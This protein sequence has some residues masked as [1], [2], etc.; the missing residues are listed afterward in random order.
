M[1]NLRF[2]LVFICLSTLSSCSDEECPPC[3]TPPEMFVFNIVDE[4]SGENVFVSGAYD[5]NDLKVT[6][7][8]NNKAIEYDYISENNLGYI[9]IH[10]IGWQTEIVNYHFTIGDQT[11]F[12]F[13]VDAMRKSDDCCSFTEFKAVE[14]G[15]AKYSQ[16]DQSGLYQVIIP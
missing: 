6:N 5:I 8:L 12:T 14:L 4:A 3:F 7:V 15:E 10:T 13:Y 11:F 9:K 1:K 16:E 2:L